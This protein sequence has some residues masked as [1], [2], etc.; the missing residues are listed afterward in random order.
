[1]LVEALARTVDDLVELA[2][3][4]RVFG[5]PAGEHVGGGVEEPPGGAVAPVEGGI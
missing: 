5:H 1:M 3:N 4:N 2:S